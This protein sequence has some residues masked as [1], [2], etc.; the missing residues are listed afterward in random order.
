[1]GERGKVRKKEWKK[2]REMQMWKLNN[3]RR[4]KIVTVNRRV[5]CK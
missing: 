5:E 1:M 3:L 2:W 4:S